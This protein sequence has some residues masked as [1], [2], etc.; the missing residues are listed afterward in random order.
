MDFQRRI[1]DVPFEILDLIFEKLDSLQ[2]KVNLALAH[3]KLAKAFS[4]HSRKKFRKLTLDGRLTLDSWN[5]LIRECGPRIEE[6]VYGVCGR[7]GKSLLL[8]VV[9]KH[10]PNLK[11]VQF[12]LSDRKNIPSFLENMKSSLTSVKINQQSYF[13]ATILIA[14]SGI[15]QLKEFSFRGYVDEN[16]RHLDKLVAL[17][18]LSITDIKPFSTPPV[19]LLPICA[20]LKKLRNLTVVEVKILPYDEPYSTF[21]SSLEFLHLEYCEFSIELPDCPNLKYLD[22]HYPK[23]AIEG[24]VLKFILKNGKNLTELR[25]RSVPPINGNGFLDLLRGCPKLRRLRTTMEFIKLHAGFVCSILEILKE[26]GVTPE[27]PLELIICRRI[28]WKWFR[29]LH[30]RSPNAELIDLY[31]GT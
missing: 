8:K 14:V 24:Y 11:S 26:N 28:K 9:E 1:Y 30:R 21:W 16:V 18:K 5:F 4:F 7:N 17:E 12:Y 29:R 6:F 23:C 10:C 20:S 27:N 19:D 13:P 2:Y 3:E 15:T 25:E 22:M 31:E